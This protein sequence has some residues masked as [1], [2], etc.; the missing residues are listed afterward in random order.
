MENFHKAAFFW[1]S[2]FIWISSPDVSIRFCLQGLTTMMCILATGPGLWTYMCNSNTCS[3]HAPD[4][5]STHAPGVLPRLLIL[6]VTLAVTYWGQDTGPTKGSDLAGI[7]S[8]GTGASNSACHW[9]RYIFLYRGNGVQHYPDAVTLP[10]KS[11]LSLTPGIYNVH[12]TGGN[13]L[14]TG[15]L[16]NRKCQ[17]R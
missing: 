16:R 5:C 8:C 12:G 17:W 3:T 6:E 10:P 4:Y 2:V 13:V 15:L 7:N 11:G 1:H 14:S 9:C